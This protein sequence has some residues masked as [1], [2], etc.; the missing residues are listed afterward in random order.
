MI[1]TMGTASRR[2]A[3]AALAQYL[4]S[5]LPALCGVW[6]AIKQKR[7][8]IRLHRVSNPKNV[9]FPLA[10]FMSTFAII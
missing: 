5:C 6:G 3:P 10:P 2:L 9:I 7:A 1:T 4:R 8:W